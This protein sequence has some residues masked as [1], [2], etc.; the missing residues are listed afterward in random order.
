MALT[1][2]LHHACAGGHTLLV[3][4]LIEVFGC[5]PMARDDSG[6]TPLHVAA[7][8][9]REEVVRMLVSKYKCPLLTV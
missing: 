6:S 7:E 9:G 8:H 3:T 5:D 4:Q 1:A 2:A